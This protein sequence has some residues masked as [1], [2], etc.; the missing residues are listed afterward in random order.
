MSDD[1]IKLVSDPCSGE[2]YRTTTNDKNFRLMFDPYSGKTY[3]ITTIK[4]IK[5]PPKDTHLCRHTARERTM[6]ENILELYIVSS[7]G[8]GGY[9]VS[10]D[11]SDPE[12]GLEVYCDCPAGRNSLLCKH[13]KLI[14]KG[15]KSIFDPEMYNN[16]FPKEEWEL[17]RKLIK[18]YG[19]DKLLIKYDTTLE[20]LEKESKKALAELEKE[21]KRIRHS[22][23]SKKKKLLGMFSGIKPIKG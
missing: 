1:N 22:L 11:F 12:E 2:I 20:P 18:E 8:N 5:P 19:V 6:D 17:S 4:G 9:C 10:F 16:G 3:R 7:S 23:N 15:D 14:I 13:L 21:K